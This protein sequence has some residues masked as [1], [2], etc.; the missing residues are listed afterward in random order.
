MH[1]VRIS[2]AASDNCGTPTVSLSVTSSE[3][4][5]GTGDGDTAPD[6][7]VVGP[8]LVRLRA[9]RAGN[10][11]GRTYTVAIT[12]TDSAGNASTQAVTVAV[13]HNR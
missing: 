9:E 3:P 13:P 2:Y 8:N 11:T 1:D 12:A 5:S 10:G 6:W 4:V 7:E